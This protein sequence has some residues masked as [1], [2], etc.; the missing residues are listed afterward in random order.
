MRLSRRSFLILGSSLYLAEKLLLD[1]AAYLSQVFTKCVTRIRRSLLQI[2]HK[3]QLVPQRAPV[4][5][6][7]CLPPFPLPDFVR[8]AQ[9]IVERVRIG[10]HTSI[11]IG[12]HNVGAFDCEVAEASGL[13]A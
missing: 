10:K 2:L 7:L 9:Q 8:D 5:Y 4:F 13:Q 6:R 1:C 11:I 12:E 3:L